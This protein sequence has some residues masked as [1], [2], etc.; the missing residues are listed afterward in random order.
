MWQD[1]PFKIASG[2]DVHDA[3]HKR[4]QDPD[5][6]WCDHDYQSYADWQKD[7]SEGMD[8]E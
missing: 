4:S 3:Y 1:N 2:K 7:Q 6:P 8:H 5:C